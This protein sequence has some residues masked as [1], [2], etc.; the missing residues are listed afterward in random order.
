MRIKNAR[1]FPTAFTFAQTT[2]RDWFLSVIVKATFRLEHRL[3]P[4]RVADRQ[5]PILTADEP[6]DTEVV[7]GALKFESDL[8]PFKPR[9]DVLL[10]GQA[11]APFGRPQRSV[12]VALQVGP[13]HKQ[14]RVLGERRWSFKDLRDPTPLVAGPLEFVTMPLTWDRAYGGVDEQAGVRSDVPSFRPWFSQNIVGRGFSGAR[15]IESVDER[16]LPNLEDPRDPVRSWDSRPCPTGCGYFPRNSEPR[17]RYQGTYDERWKAER[18]PAPPKDFCFD[19]YNAADPELQVQG[20]LRGNERAMLQNVTLGGGRI[21]FLLPCIRPRFT[22]TRGVNPAERVVS[23]APAALDTLLLLPDAASFVV[24][25]RAAI[26][27]CV[28]EASD[29]E[30]VRIEYE[31]LPQPE[32]F[33]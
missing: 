5:L 2:E 33:R 27:P 3:F 12:D 20:Y 24:I 15:T 10:V 19:Y 9:T 13:V 25:W 30:E 14:I 28:P 23:E 17:V 16:V 32:V 1:I 26:V 6:Y 29:V 11:H 7:D 18:A 22:V 21:D 4:A 8:V 31:A